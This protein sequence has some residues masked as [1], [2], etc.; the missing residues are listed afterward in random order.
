MLATQNYILKNAPLNKSQDFDALR[1][2]GIETIAQ[3]S[4]QLWTD[5]NLHDPGITILES[6]CYAMTDIGLR[7]AYPMRDL[8]TT[9]NK[10]GIPKNEGDF[11]TARPILSNFPV[12]FDDLRKI[13][14]DIKGIRMAWVRK[15]DR[16][17]YKPND[18]TILTESSQTA[19][20]T[21]LGL[22]DI[23]LEY[24]EGVLSTSQLDAPLSQKTV[25]ENVISKLHEYRNLCEDF[26]EICPMEKEEIAI[27]ADI[28][29]KPY[30][31]IEQ[32]EAE[33]FAR[34]ADFISPAVRF[35]TL[36]EMVA[37]GKSIE[38]IFE[39]P[40]LENGFI[41][42]DE[43]Q[44]ITKFNE[45]KLSDLFQIISDIDGVIAIRQIELV[46]FRKGIVGETTTSDGANWVHSLA[47]NQLSAPI[48]AEKR[49][50]IFFYKN[51]LPYLA[52]KD[53]VQ[54][55]LQ[56]KKAQDVHT[57]SNHA[58]QAHSDLDFRVPIGSFRDLGAYESIQ[59]DLPE[60]YQ[61]GQNRVPDSATVLRKAQA[62]QLKG[63]LLHFDQILLN[64]VSQLANLKMLFSWADTST[65]ASYFTSPLPKGTILGLETLYNNF[66]TLST[67]LQKIIESPESAITRKNDFLNHLTAR[68]AETLTEYS[69]LMET[70]YPDK[71]QQMEIIKDK[72]R[73]L[74]NYPA[75]SAQRLKGFR[76]SDCGF[77]IS[78]FIDNE[79]LTN[80][81]INNPKSETRNPKSAI[82]NPKSEIALSGYQKRV[83]ALLGINEWIRQPLAGHCLIIRE[84]KI[85]SH[86]LKYR[87][88]LFDKNPSKTGAKQL[89]K[90]ELCENKQ[91]IE[92]LLDDA[93]EIGSVEAHFNA[94]GELWQDCNTHKNKI[95]KLTD[96][97]YLKTVVA[98]FKRYAEIE[99]FHLVEPILLR[100]RT[101]E[102][103]F[104]PIHVDP[105]KENCDCPEVT[106]A[107]S[108]R[109]SIYLPSW[110]KRF[111]KIRFRQHV[112]K[113]LREECPA[114]IF[115]K[116]CWVSHVQMALFEDKYA[117]WLNELCKLPKGNCC[118]TAPV[119]GDGPKMQR[120]GITPLP[121]KTDS[122]AVYAKS[123]KD[124]I[125]NMLEIDNVFPT[126]R[127]HSCEETDG[128]NP[129][130]SLDNTSLGTL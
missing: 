109:I 90:S 128:D 27:C 55:L 97:K 6:L 20:N 72:Q 74:A 123:L 121:A 63:Y 2:E 8:L 115:P 116:I 54:T 52:N 62:Q 114:H 38:S 82:H 107:Y 47:K 48:F 75:V 58:L 99:G 19:R 79:L 86:N 45:L 125:E 106:D 10:D 112:E 118:V 40:N 36:S 59:N 65:P 51:N 89:F 103:I 18:T 69:Q 108:F 49:S 34:L 32:I 41:D 91:V 4:H 64:A 30:A 120:D 95:G 100:P 111:K 67:Q 23:L 84:R 93:L 9:L 104:M 83:Y 53:K 21:M 29:L 3:L 127:L 96:I 11:H 73:L 105:N 24:E 85:P 98:Y 44:Q 92:A 70:L 13:L 122:D 37:K 77:R 87:F 22:Y 126:A 28:D 50:K 26:I 119:L 31:N 110:S 117:L 66:T 42:D 43:F 60:T 15:N 12:T 16:V 78:E 61:V 1:K 101:Q 80:A 81:K 35:Y 5:Y 113:V 130:I 129:E 124:F 102:D 76:I 33:I 7:T 56:Q 14:I 57:K 68:F 17:S 25:I 94:V 39:G 88:V 71:S 46:S